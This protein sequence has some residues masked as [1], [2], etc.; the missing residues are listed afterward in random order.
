MLYAFDMQARGDD[1]IDAAR[2]LL[3]VGMALY[4]AGKPI[5]FVLYGLYCSGPK[6]QRGT[7]C[8]GIHARSYRSWLLLT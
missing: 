6:A 4:A 2:V 1:R 8:K 3:L 5:C 7:A